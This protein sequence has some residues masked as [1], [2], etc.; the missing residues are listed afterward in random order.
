[1]GLENRILNGK[2]KLYRCGNWGVD[3][4]IVSLKEIH[5]VITEG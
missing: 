5:D 2:C 1:M 4:M 3:W